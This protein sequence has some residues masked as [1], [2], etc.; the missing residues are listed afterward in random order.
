MFIESTSGNFCIY[1][2]LTPNNFTVHCVEECYA[3]NFTLYLLFMFFMTQQATYTYTHTKSLQTFVGRATMQTVA[4]INSSLTAQ[5]LKW[6]FLKPLLNNENV[7]QHWFCRQRLSPKGLAIKY[8]IW[9]YRG[10]QG[11]LKQPVRHLRSR[12]FSSF[13]ANHTVDIKQETTVRLL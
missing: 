3:L 1:G 6:I 7:S 4:T 13:F 5:K 8:C 2:T 10:F 11:P 9:S 12:D